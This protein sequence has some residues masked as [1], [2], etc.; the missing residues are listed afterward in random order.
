MKTNVYFVLIVDSDNEDI[1]FE[2]DEENY[3]DEF[4]RFTQDKN[5]KKHNYITSRTKKI[6][7]ESSVVTRPSSKNKSGKNQSLYG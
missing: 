5:A 4:I 2:I 7:T 1:G 3:G 6:R